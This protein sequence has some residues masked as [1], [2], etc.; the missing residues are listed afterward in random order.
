MKP[1]FYVQETD[2]YTGHWALEP[3][4]KDGEGSFGEV[5][6]LRRVQ[7]RFKR[8]SRVFFLELGMV[9]NM[10]SDEQPRLSG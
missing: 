1:F 6:R 9:V 5:Q 10:V 2:L 7:S 8:V 4:E 3:T